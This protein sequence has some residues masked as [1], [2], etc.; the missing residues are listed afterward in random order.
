MYISSRERKIIELL[1]QVDGDIPVRDIAKTLD[2]SERTIHRD[3][4][5]V[6]EIV[7]NFDLSLSK[8]S[9]VGHRLIGTN[10]AKHDL[11]TAISTLS[12]SEFTSEERQAII[13]STLLEAKEPTKLFTLANE[14]DVSLATI[15]NDL[16]QLETDMEAFN[17]QLIRKRGYGVEI[18]GEEIKKR[19]ALSQLITKYVEPF[20]FVALRNKENRS[21]LDSPS[22]MISRRLLESVDMKKLFV[23]QNVVE[24]ARRELPHE[25][26]DN[27]YI[28]LVVHLALAMERL[29]KGETISF[30]PDYLNQLSGTK[31]YEIAS[32]IIHDLHLALML[33]IPEDEIGYITM[34]L[35][36]AKLQLSEHFFIEDSSMDMAVKAT[37]LIQFVS[38]HLEVDLTH[39]GSLLNDLVAHLRPTVYRLKQGMPIKNPMLDVIKDDYQELFDLIGQGVH[40]IF[41]D[42][43][44]PDAEIGYLVLHFAAALLNK[45]DIWINALVICSSGIGTA[46]MLASKLLQKF[47]EIKQVENKSMFDVPELDLNNY[48]MIVSTIPL[49]GMDGEYILTSPMLS[50]ADIHRI[51][52]MIRKRK[53]QT[54][55]KALQTQSA[56]NVALEQNDFIH[57]LKAT[58]AYAKIILELLELFAVYELPEKKS[59]EVLL[60]ETCEKLEK[61]HVIQDKEQVI[62]KLVK[63]EQQSG[64][65]IPSTS[66]VFYH[67]RSAAVLKPVIQVYTLK[68]PL[69]IT[70]MDQKDMVASTILLMLAPDNTSNEVLEILSFI[71]NLFIQREESA[72]V[73]ET[74][75]E[76]RI[77][78]FLTE[79]FQQF[80]KGK[81][82]F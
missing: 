57:N 21:T 23:I 29:Q 47:P 1:V 17:L 80:M 20:K 74:G 31:E 78:E 25:L 59:M 3:M 37:E 33:D 79:Q 44:F 16:D 39:Q 28:G 36:G 52:K 65:G 43:K 7:S 68:T 35:M 62:E 6:A 45:K 15:S 66:I 2:V 41:T 69:V 60:H 70:G 50:D 82:L 77:R 30:D 49:S 75:N 40:T 22:E 12:S 71:S 11:K 26:A 55:A 51:K 64:L 32:R 63:R 13:L 56:G 19:A 24:K 42:L 34:H 46:K 48:D 72:R 8:Q 53:L 61:T 5:N 81:N 67:T 14:L 27:S 73:F 58:Q 10:Q 4:K 76:G 18:N 38:S 54:R 9:G